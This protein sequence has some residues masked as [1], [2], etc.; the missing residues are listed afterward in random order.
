LKVIRTIDGVAT[1]L[2]EG[3]G[4][5]D[6]QLNENGGDD[7]AKGDEQ[8]PAI[9]FTTP[10]SPGEEIEVIYQGDPGFTAAPIQ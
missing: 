5:N 2:Q 3:S 7:C 8:L 9:T 4:P 1:E 6:Y 10:P